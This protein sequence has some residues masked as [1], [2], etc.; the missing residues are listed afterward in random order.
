MGMGSSRGR[1]RTKKFVLGVCV[2]E[3]FGLAQ[4]EGGEERPGKGRAKGGQGFSRPFFVRGWRKGG[5]GE[6]SEGEKNGR[7]GRPDDDARELGVH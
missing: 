3:V 4:R 7:E 2:W 1:K 5:G 6:K